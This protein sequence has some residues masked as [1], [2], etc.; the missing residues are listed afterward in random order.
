LDTQAKTGK[1]VSSLKAAPLPLMLP[2]GFHELLK[3]AA[4]FKPPPQGTA[5]PSFPYEPPM[6]RGSYVVLLWPDKDERQSITVRAVKLGNYLDVCNVQQFSKAGALLQENPI[7]LDTSRVLWIPDAAGTPNANAIT[8]G[9]NRWSI[10]AVSGKA[11]IFAEDVLAL[12]AGDA[13]G[14]KFYF[15]VPAGR[16]QFGLSLLGEKGEWAAYSVFDPSGKKVASWEKVTANAKQ[17]VPVTQP[18][19]WCISV[20]HLVDDGGFG[21]VDLPN[22]F[23]LRPGDVMIGGDGSN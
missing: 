1:V 7:P 15:Y 11:M 21:L 19:I 17:T 20:D 14:G 13:P 12:N 4:G 18:G 16:K 5:H 23:A 9:M 8:A 3:S 10:D 22:L 2:K 6:L